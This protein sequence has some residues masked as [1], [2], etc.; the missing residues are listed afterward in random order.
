MIRSLGIRTFY[1]SSK[2]LAQLYT[3]TTLR[4][5]TYKLEVPEKFQP[6]SVLVLAT[7]SNL[8]SV[9]DEAIS[10]HQQRGLQVIVAGV[11]SVVPNSCRNGVS[12]MWLSEPAAIKSSVL[13]DSRDDLNDKPR[14][15]D[16]IRIVVARKNWK[17]MNSNLSLQLSTKAKVDL[18]LANSVFTTDNLVTLFYFQSSSLAEQLEN[19]G[20]TLCE[21]SLEL[22]KGTV[23]ENPLLKYED[24]WTALYDSQEEPFVI[25]N[26]VGNLV[27]QIN[28]Q[29]ASSYL[30]NNKRLMGLGSKDTEVYVKLYKK[31]DPQTAFRYKVVAGGG[32]WGAKA[33]IIALSTDAKLEKGDRIEFFMLTPTDRFTMSDS[34]VPK[35]ELVGKLVFE[36]TYEEQS[37]GSD[38]AG[39]TETLEYVFGS[40]SEGEF[41]FNDVKHNSAGER[42][43]IDIEK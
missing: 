14:E 15:S 18:K 37:Y 33:S 12:E 40:G 21:L 20:Q 8:P 36:S 4:P 25:T 28:K 30:E 2:C 7:P 5:V 3:R 11:D 38:S 13:L 31:N 34:E 10:I 26:C 32:G 9:I 1:S 23:P 6:Q 24:K 22:P 19:S 29:P 17:N 41:K 16:G 39:E 43:I 27:K 42:L 35:E